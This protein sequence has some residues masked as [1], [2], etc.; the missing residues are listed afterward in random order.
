M[1][2]TH[3]VQQP[4]SYSSLMIIRV[5]SCG[6]VRLLSCSSSPPTVARLESDR[7]PLR[8]F[9]RTWWQLACNTTCGW[10]M[11]PCA[12]CG[13]ETERLQGSLLLCPDCEQHL[14]RNATITELNKRLHAAGEMYRAALKEQ[15]QAY[16]LRAELGYSN[17]RASQIIKKA[18]VQVETAAR[19]Y[20]EALRNFT[21][22]FM[23]RNQK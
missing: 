10:F 3:G 20:R 9:S 5:A 7:A 14:L 12:E 13:N 4:I 18:V 6:R 17:P 19:G 22:E 11:G 23:R 8:F 16:D 2:V 1:Q 21:V 15:R